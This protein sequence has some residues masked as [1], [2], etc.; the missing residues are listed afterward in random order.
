M[1]EPFP[2]WQAAADAFGAHLDVC[3]QCE[4]NP[5]ALCAIGVRLLQAT[6]CD[7][8]IAQIGADAL[9]QLKKED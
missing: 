4:E 3:T 7:P 5:F 6:A 9:E 8:V 1:I 2:G